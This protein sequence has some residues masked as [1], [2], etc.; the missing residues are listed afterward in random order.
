MRKRMRIGRY[1]LTGAPRSGKTT[2]I[3]ELS[4]HCKVF[5]EPVSRIVKQQVL[6]LKEK[7][8]IIPAHSVSL[9]KLFPQIEVFFESCLRLFLADYEESQWLNL[10]LFDRGLPDLIVLHELLGTT[11]VPGLVSIIKEYSYSRKVFLFDLL[12]RAL[13]NIHIKQ[14]PPFRTYEECRRIGDRIAETYQQLGYDITIVPF[15]TVENRKLFVLERI[16]IPQE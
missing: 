5:E 11:I 1:I 3:R 8:E 15:D 4:S 12:D 7:G 9:S 13:F 6:S 2:V 10:S 16:D 14:R